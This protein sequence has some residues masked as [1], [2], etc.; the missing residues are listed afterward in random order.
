MMSFRLG[1]FGFLFMLLVGSSAL[2]IDQELTRSPQFRFIG[3]R[4]NA[5]GGNNP[6]LMGDV[7]GVMLNPAAIGDL[8][9]NQAFYSHRSVMDVFN[10]NA[11]GFAMPYKGFVYSL[12]YGDNIV[13]GIPETRKSQDGQIT[14]VGSFSSGFRVLHFGI[15]TQLYFDTLFLDSVSFGLGVKVLQHV[16]KSES[17]SSFGGDF[18]LVTTTNMPDKILGVNFGLER[19]H[20][21]LSALNA[22]ATDFPVI[23]V[24]RDGDSGP[25]SVSSVEEIGVANQLFLGTQLDFLDDKLKLFGG[26][27]TLSRA[28]GEYTIQEYTAG[29]EVAL[30]PELV[31]RGSLMIPDYEREKL[32]SN[33]GVGL[34]V[35]RAAGPGNQAYDLRV[36]YNMF[37]DRF[38]NEKDYT[39][40]VGVTLIGQSRDPR[41]RLIRPRKGFLTDKTETNF[42]GVAKRYSELMIYNNGVVSRRVNVDKF[43][44]WEYE[45]FPLK[46]G[47]NEIRFMSG[48]QDNSDFSDFTDP[49][50]IVSDTL[51]PSFS[52]SVSTGPDQKSL[53]LNLTSS[54][55][56]SRFDA[57][58]GDQKMKFKRI[59]PLVYQDELIL[60]ESF[61]DGAYITQKM[62]TFS[63]SVYDKVQ[64]HSP[65]FLGNFIVEVSSPTDRSVF[66]NDRITILG[67][68]SNMVSAVEVNGEKVKL[69]NYAFTHPFS[70]TDG[71]NLVSLRVQMSDGKWFNYFG[72]VLKIRRFEDIGR[73]FKGR[74]DIEFLSTMGIIKGRADGLFYPDEDMTRLDLTKFLVDLFELPIGTVEYDLFLD[75][76]VDNPDAGYVQ[77][78][79]DEGLITSFPDGTFRPDGSLSYEDAFNALVNNG[80]IESEEVVIDPEPI[81]RGEFALL[82]KQISGYSERVEY[83]LDWEQGYR[84]EASQ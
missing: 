12:S 59:S 45:K 80:I 54:E 83:L 21:G 28:S 78:A 33:F 30:F 48:S 7:G 27:D 22:F 42:K 39:H 18:G 35:N 6:V 13:Y 20:F 29:A 47:V 56:I 3:A 8:E 49:I 73:S 4:H 11:F 19:I 66:F 32:R 26:I 1:F 65:P 38:P 34:L 67:K 68:V 23:S 74:R 17:R 10:D 70:L 31:I 75:L 44:E 2:A 52:V 63:V 64:N 69:D 40:T 58:S 24:S 84:D 72:R 71:K 15:G 55:P 62:A 61:Q 51:A 50:M 77:A 9:F 41:P 60:P 53:V 46:E 76:S 5:I 37:V 43:G 81:T 36:D 14:S 16:I 79:V 57:K 82:L 25:E